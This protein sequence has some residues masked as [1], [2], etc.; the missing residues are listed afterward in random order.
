MNTETTADLYVKLL[1]RIL[2]AGA[3]NLQLVTV[4]YD[5]HGNA[6]CSKKK[7]GTTG[8]FI[9]NRVANGKVRACINNQG[10]LD[11][12]RGMS[13]FVDTCKVMTLEILPCLLFGKDCKV[14]GVVKY[15]IENHN[16]S[17]YIAVSGAATA[18][19]DVEAI[20][21][22]LIDYPQDSNGVYLIDK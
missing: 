12:L 20:K 21:G 17:G 2:Q 18:E 4:I 16:L 14:K 22:G 15:K 7:K 3:D 13:N 11:G 10:K 19:L 6:L 9:F 8:A 1:D 5:E